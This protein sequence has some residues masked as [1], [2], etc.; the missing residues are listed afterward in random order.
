MKYLLLLPLLGIGSGAV[1]ADRPPMEHVI[2]SVPIHKTAAT[3]ALPVTVL[4]GQEL[5]RAAA[6]SIGE[7]LANK[8]GIASAGFGPGVGRPVIR[9]QTGPRALTL[10]NGTSSADVSSLSPDHRVTVE[11]LL[12][13]SIEVLRGPATLLYGGGAIGG[14][15]NVID[16]RIPLKPLNGVS[17][18][19]EYRY[20]S[21][22]DMN[23][24]TGKLE[25]GNGNYAFHLSGTTRD[26]N[27]LDIPGSAANRDVF[28]AEVETTYGY[29]ANTDGEDD[30]ITVGNS[31][32]FGD[33]GFVG[34]SV[35]HLESEYGVPPGAHGDEEADD[36]DGEEETVRLDIEQTRYDGML[37]WH[38]L[39]P[40]IAD[41]VRASLTYTDYSHDELEGQEIG[42]Q[43]FRDTWEG[44]VE[45]VHDGTLHGVFGGQ[46][47]QD[48]FE[49]V[50][51]E[52][53]VPQT[54]STEL[55]VFLLEDFHPLQSLRVELGA[56][57]DYV[58]RD[59]D[60]TR[61]GDESF[62]SVSASAAA[63]WDIDTSWNFSVSLARAQRAPATEELYSNIDATNP[64]QLVVHA[65]TGVIEIGDPSL[66]NESSINLDV[67]LN[68]TGTGAWA[69][70]NLFYNDFD[71][72]IALFNSGGEVVSVPLY[73]YAQQDAVFYGVELQSEFEL[74]AVGPG[75]LS[76]E[77]FGDYINAE[78][79]DDKHVPRMPPGRLGAEFNWSNE[80]TGVFL[81]VLR[82]ADQNDPGEFEE[83]T[84]GYTRWDAGADYRMSLAKDAE[85]LF[86]LKWKNIGDE[87]YRQSTSFL[88]DFAPQAGRSVE[89]GLR[90]SF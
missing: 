52:A 18:A 19:A 37:H 22:S 87:D 23:S 81:R 11:A 35:S 26:Y 67:G 68:W 86:F 62:T 50:G 34:F 53:Y 69:E 7:T 78:F 39:S 90:Y 14:V 77:L 59:P 48:Q 10:Q 12:A 88:R 32:H 56:R 31:Y 70:L 66:D 42:T 9:G 4:S 40:G 60:T 43:Y 84:K 54:D 75:A 20:D 74:F 63:L 17:G 38:G 36:E 61:A 51:D 45:I 29:I 25:G 80:A 55:G 83:E 2:V 33:T 24:A 49:A 47:K 73:R 30:A 28:G 6:T 44:R 1:G 5:Q 27:D 15:V 57:A 46:W 16:S 3:T 89:A 13:D 76:L 8:P 58:E 71:D 65:A 41:V 21:G 72:Y 79:S 64:D 82:A 85:L